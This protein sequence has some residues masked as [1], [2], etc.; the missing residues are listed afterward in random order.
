[1]TNK[2]NFGKEESLCKLSLSQIKFNLK[3]Q[4]KWDRCPSSQVSYVRLIC[5]TENNKYRKSLTICSGI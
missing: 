3:S 5:F 4:I 2:S 1:M